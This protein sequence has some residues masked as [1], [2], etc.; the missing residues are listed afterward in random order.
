MFRAR[1]PWCWETAMALRWTGVGEQEPHSSASACPSRSHPQHGCKEVDAHPTFP[2]RLGVTGVCFPSEGVESDLLSRLDC[3]YKIRFESHSQAKSLLTVRFKIV[4]S[5]CFPA[6]MENIN[7][8]LSHLSVHWKL[9][10]QKGNTLNRSTSL[11]PGSQTHSPDN[12]G[13]FVQF[14]PLPQPPNPLIP[15]Y[16]TQILEYYSRKFHP[17]P[18]SKLWQE[19]ALRYL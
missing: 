19:K 17:D 13:K 9:H 7:G 18:E 8:I 6:A 5:A 11:A 14:F 1:K 4:E 3:L 10:I 16:V 15:A 2:V 12:W